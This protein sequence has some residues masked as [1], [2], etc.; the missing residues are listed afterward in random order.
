M[1]RTPLTGVDAGLPPLGGG[2]SY[3]APVDRDARRGTAGLAGSAV[4][5]PPLAAPARPD[6]RDTDSGD[7]SVPLVEPVQLWPPPAP[8][9]SY[10]AG[11]AGSGKTF[12]VKDWQTKERGLELCAT[13]GIAALNLGGTT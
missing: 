10:L 13:T 1:N 7:Q 9:F 2:G 8:A 4:L 3:A 12:A 11:A 5:D 6:G